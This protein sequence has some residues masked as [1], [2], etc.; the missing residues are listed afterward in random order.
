MG[1]T[2]FLGEAIHQVFTLAAAQGESESDV[3]A[4]ARALGKVNGVK[5][6]PQE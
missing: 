2:A 1:A 4:L 5:I 6:G 3:P